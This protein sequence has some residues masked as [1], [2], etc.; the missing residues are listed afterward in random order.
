MA[1][2]RRVTPPSSPWLS[3]QEASERSGISVYTYRNWAR[4]RLIP[5][6]YLNRM[7]R[8]YLI[9]RDFVA[10]PMPLRIPPAATSEWE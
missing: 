4:N 6:Q 3:L 5:R 1:G 9:H 7:R 10:R 2:R 8:R